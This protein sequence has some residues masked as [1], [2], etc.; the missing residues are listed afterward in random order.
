MNVIFEF[1]RKPETRGTVRGLFFPCECF[2]Q[3]YWVKS[4]WVR[5]KNAMWWLRA[6]QGFWQGNLCCMGAPEALPSHVLT[7]SVQHRCAVG[8]V[9]AFTH[10]LSSPSPG[11]LQQASSHDLRTQKYL[12]T[13]LKAFE[14]VPLK[15]TSWSIWKKKIIPIT[16]KWQ[17]QSLNT[18]HHEELLPVP[19]EENLYTENVDTTVLKEQLLWG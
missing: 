3:L 1:I 8:P 4:W 7:G 2:T 16:G 9:Q 18:F 19:L 11:I 14:E 10:L 13:K 15:L 5:S 6:C 12:T 17:H